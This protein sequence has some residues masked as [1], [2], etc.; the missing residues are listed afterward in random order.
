MTRLGLP[1]IS[2]RYRRSIRIPIPVFFRS[3]PWTRPLQCP[4][5]SEKLRLAQPCFGYKGRQSVRVDAGLLSAVLGPLKFGSAVT[6]QRALAP[7]MSA[8]GTTMTRTKPLG[9]PLP[10]IGSRSVER[11]WSCAT[12]WG[13]SPAAERPCFARLS[14]SLGEP[15][16]VGARGSRP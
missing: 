14:Q 12:V 6:K 15:P 3:Q 16:G 13:R 1:R 9:H 7:A 11:R 2:P 5:P 10:M 8:L 4:T